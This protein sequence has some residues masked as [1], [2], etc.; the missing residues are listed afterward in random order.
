MSYEM[1]Q[2]GGYNSIVITERIR[3]TNGWLV[4]TRI[5]GEYSKDV[6]VAQSFV[7]DEQ[8]RYNN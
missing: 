6:S 8:F 4:R 1:M 5:R 3:V 2:E 7:P